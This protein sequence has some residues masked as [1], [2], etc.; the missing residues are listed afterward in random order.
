MTCSYVCRGVVVVKIT[1]LDELSFPKV[2]TSEA[3]P[4]L[5]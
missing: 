2:M 1:Y 4:D 3:L 5:S